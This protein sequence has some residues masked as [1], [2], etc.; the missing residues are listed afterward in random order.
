[1]KSLRISLIFFSFYINITAQCTSTNTISNLNPVCEDQFLGVQ[2]LGI[3][4]INLLP[5]NSANKHVFS[6]VGESD[7]DT[8]LALYD[9]S[10][11]LILSNND[12][13]DCG[14]CKQSTITYGPVSGGG[15]AVGHYLILSRPGCSSLNF[16]TNL[17]YSARNKYDSDP[18]ITIPLDIVQCIGSR[19]N[20][21]YSLPSGVI[22]DNAGSTWESL[23]TDVASIDNSGAAVFFKAGIARIKLKVKS[24]CPVINNYI[25]KGSTTSVITRKD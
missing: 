7:G 9:S 6:T 5:I 19:I 15:N 12:D 20:F 13:P 3:I 11:N 25:V 16:T 24:S 10:N 18:Q 17:K 22:A 14:G 2:S 4:R 8:F 23:D 21:S 1:M